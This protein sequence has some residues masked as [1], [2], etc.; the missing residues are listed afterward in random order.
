MKKERLCVFTAGAASALAIADHLFFVS[1]ATGFVTA[2]SVWLRY[3]AFAAVLALL[4]IFSRGV[5]APAGELELFEK[6]SHGEAV[7]AGIFFLGSGVIALLQM[8]APMAVLAAGLFA[9]AVFFFKARRGRP[10]F[11]LG[12]MLTV[13]MLYCCLLR[14]L[15]KPASNEH[16]LSSFGLL[17]S[18][19]GLLFALRL[20]RDVFLPAG[21]DLRSLAFWGIAAAVCG[22][23][24][25]FAKYL[26]CVLGAD[27]TFWQPAFDFPLLGLAV[28]GMAAFRRAFAAKDKPAE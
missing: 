23:G 28:V 12:C 7:L 15:Q 10:S 19:V 16:L 11:A 1:P 18:I 14:Y 6:M 22:G 5:P 27:R 13:T 21:R 3:G 25:N 4:F 24:L 20:L 2:G 17:S 8:T 9:G 26:I